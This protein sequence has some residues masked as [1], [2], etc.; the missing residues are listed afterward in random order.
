MFPAFNVNVPLPR[1]TA[2]PGSYNKPAQQSSSS[3]TVS[4]AAEATQ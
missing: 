2:L 3:V 1:D 4:K